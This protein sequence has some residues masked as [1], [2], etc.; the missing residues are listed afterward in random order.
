[1]LFQ[2]SFQ[3]HGYFWEYDKVQLLPLAFPEQD[4]PTPPPQ[5]YGDYHG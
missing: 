3:K 5:K 4:T 1:M 2:N